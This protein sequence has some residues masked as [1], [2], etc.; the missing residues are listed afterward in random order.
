MAEIAV[1]EGS[2][3]QIIAKSQRQQVAVELPFHYSL[4]IQGSLQ[5]VDISNRKAEAGS[6]FVSLFL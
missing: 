2:S 1:E 4:P 5:L 6:N 3:S